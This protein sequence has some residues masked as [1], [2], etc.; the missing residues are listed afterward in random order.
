[1]KISATFSIY[2]GMICIAVAE[3]DLKAPEPLE[4]VTFESARALGRAQSRYLEDHN[5][6][7]DRREAPN[8]NLA[9]FRESV[10]PALMKSCLTCHGPDISEGRLNVEALDPDLLTGASVDQWREVYNVLSN[11]EMP[12]DDEPEFALSDEE[13]RNIVD[14]LSGELNKASQ[15]RRRGAEKSSFR[16]FTNYEYRYVLEDLLG[17]SFPVE[18]KLPPETVSEDG[19]KNRSELLQMSAMQFETYRDIAL[20]ALKRAT[21]SGERP[22]P[23][24]YRVSMRQLMEDA[25]KGKNAKKFNVTDPANRKLRNRQH[26]FHRESG[27]A[28]QFSNGKALP[29]SQGGLQQTPEESGILLALPR[30]Q[31]LKLNLDRFL[32]DEGTMRVTIRAGRSTMNPNEF[33]SLRLGFSAHTS[34]NANFS[35][36]ISQRDVPVTASIDDPQLLHFDIQLRDIQRNPFRKLST[37]F[38]RRDEFLHIRNIS[39]SGGRE[40]PFHV[41][42]EYIEIVAPF[43]EQWPPRTHTNIFFESDN[44]FDEQI[45]GREVLGRFLR[46]VWRRSVSPQ[47]LDAFMELFVKFRPEFE[48]FEDAMLEV[49]ATALATPEFLY[50]TQRIASDASADSEKISQLELANRLALFLWCSIPDDELID[51]AEQGKLRERESLSEQIDRMLADPRSKRFTRHFVE[52]WLGTEG[53]ESV[54]HVKDETLKEAMKEEPVAFFDHVLRE[55]RS[56]MD[57]IHSDYALVN[58]RLAAHYRIPNVYGPDFRKVSIESNTHRGGVLTGAA[59][60]AM[61]SDGTDSN[62]LKRGVWMLERILDDPPPPPP[63]DVPEVDLTDPE[64]LK[65]TLK[66]RIADHRNKPACVSCH[67]RIDPWGIAF[68]NYDALGEFRTRIKDKPV[69]ANAELF[70]KQSLAGMDG[71]K[72]HLLTD[73]QDQFARAIVHKLTAY[74]LGRPLAFADHADA[75]DLTTEFRQQDDRLSDLIHLVVRSNL[76]NA[77]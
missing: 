56:V 47:E 67:S 22:D 17:V 1:M 21:V 55:N 59:V 64:I 27:E 72:K 70:G 57:F 62:P 63:P 38:P 37:P 26:Y 77:K 32:P 42:I 23:V 29:D 11:S 61:N 60:L 50:L 13:R 19:F 48:T 52:Q 4:S 18:D 45:Y 33:A 44:R 2:L 69:D 15:A 20:Q 5:V 58:E 65:M 3:D 34:N 46:R 71:L 6:I 43:Y 41:S 68:E 10:R 40:E 51:V 73:R 66:E 31:E 54:T 35:E 28:I 76:F 36:V 9:Y 16:R 39:N 74:A 25:A 8:A 30:S 53:L 12:P 49:L 75:E 14:W 7:S 24:T